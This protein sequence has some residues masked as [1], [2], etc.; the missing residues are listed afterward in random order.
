MQVPVA[1]GKNLRENDRI[2]GMGRCG[3]GKLSDIE[4]KN[5]N[6]RK[7]FFQHNATSP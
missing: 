7:A 1:D 6:R 2:F 5:E 3:N 4:K